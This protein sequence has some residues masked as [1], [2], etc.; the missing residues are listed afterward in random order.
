M[1]DYLFVFFKQKTAY[2]M[3]ISDWSSDV[4]SSD[5]DLPDALARHRELL[6]HFLQRVIGVH[7]DA[8]A[9]PEHALLARG[10]R[11]EHAGHRFL[12]VGVDRGI[13]WNDCVLV[14]DEIAEVRILLVAD[15]RFQA[16][17]LLGDLH[18]LADLLKRSEEHTSNS[19]C[20]ER[21]CQ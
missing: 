2:G 4:C 3:R 13:N 6:A 14:L 19:S 15:R 7:A 18:H 17:R 11:G 8:K 5:L 10:E 12:E 20:R 21:M 16:D 1:L 9:H